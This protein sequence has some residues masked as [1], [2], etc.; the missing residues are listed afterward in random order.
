MSSSNFET[1][2]NSKTE[3]RIMLHSDVC[4]IFSFF[5]V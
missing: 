1:I 3:V 2:Q 5:S 4:Y